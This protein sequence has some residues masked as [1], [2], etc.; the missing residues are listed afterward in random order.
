MSPLGNGAAAGC[1]APKSSLAALLDGIID[2]VQRLLRQQVELVRVEL[3]EDVRRLAFGLVVAINGAVLLAVGGLLLGFALA[4]FL[5]WIVAPHLPLWV[6]YL[7]VAGAG[8]LT[9]TVLMYV[10]WRKFNAAL[11]EQSLAAL[12]ENL[13]W[14]TNHVTTPR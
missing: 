8:L 7:I 9:G 10:A 14:T 6:C 4:H 2:D 11:P 1:D 3:K 12:K 5:E 13:Q